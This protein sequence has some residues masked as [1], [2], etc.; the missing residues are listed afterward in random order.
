MLTIWLAE[1]MATERVLPRQQPVA[2]RPNQDD[3][4]DEYSHMG[5]QVPASE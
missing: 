2:Y 3:Q 1:G 5:Q 4:H